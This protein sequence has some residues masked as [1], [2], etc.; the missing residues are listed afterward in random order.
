MRLSSTGKNPC[1]P[2]AGIRDRDRRPCEGSSKASATQPV[3][4]ARTASRCHR[5]AG[6]R[7]AWLIY[8]PDTFCAK[9][10]PGSAV[11]PDGCAMISRRVGQRVGLIFML[12]VAGHSTPM[13]GI[14]RSS[15]SYRTVLVL[16]VLLG[17]PIAVRSD[18]LED[19]ARELARKIV[20]ALTAQNEVSVE[21][22]NLSSL[23]PEDLARID[24]TLK[25]ELH[26]RDISTSVKG[27]A[28]VSLVVTLS[29][30]LSGLVW[31]AEIHEGDGSR[32]LL[33]AVP[34]AT[35]RLSHG[36]ALPVVLRGERFWEGPERVI[37]ATTVA[38]LNGEQQLALLLPNALIIRNTLKDS[39]TRIE[40]PLIISMPTLREPTGTLSQHGN[41]LEADHDPRICTISVDTKVLLECHNVR[42]ESFSMLPR[43]ISGG[44]IGRVQADCGGRSLWLVTGTGDDTQPDTIQV[45]ESR[46]RRS[47]KASNQLN[48][49]G[50]VLALHDASDG[51]TATAI[52]RNLST[53]NYEAYRLSISC[54][55]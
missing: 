3:A 47:I 43:G 8:L 2:L 53:R 31:I 6:V 46:D 48:L 19:S 13:T 18:T 42:G 7:S 32:V 41:I 12:R 45:L 29:E 16:L 9:P 1:G 39:E 38:A 55:E 27:G 20:A 5:D 28:A 21:V 35:A 40:I 26:T 24:E 15:L 14:H 50:P 51:P 36:E 17:T 25:A 44:Q 33:S 34:Y 4:S 22:R 52:V 54:Q 37:D 30:N 49:P 11:L 10:E 23:T